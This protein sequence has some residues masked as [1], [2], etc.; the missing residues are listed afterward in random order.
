MDITPELSRAGRGFLNWSRADLARAAGVS[1]PVVVKFEHGGNL[2][3]ET[4]AKLI[5]AFSANGVTFTNGP[6]VQTIRKDK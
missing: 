4:L 1:T 2:Q 6:R 3:A 5:A